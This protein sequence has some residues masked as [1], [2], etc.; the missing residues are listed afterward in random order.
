MSFCVNVALTWVAN[1][2]VAEHRNEGMLWGSAS[3]KCGKSALPDNGVA[4]M[5]MF[6]LPIML[7]GRNSRVTEQWNTALTQ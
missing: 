3:T 4:G 2:E 6:H 1:V 5:T 7:H